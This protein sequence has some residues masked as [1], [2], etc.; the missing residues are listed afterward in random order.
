MWRKLPCYEIQCRKHILLDV[1]QG[2][3]LYENI[4]K[5]FT[6]AFLT[7]LVARLCRMEYA[8]LASGITQ[9]HELEDL[10]RAIFQS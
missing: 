3:D 8:N 10:E 6:H 4:I 9:F 5:D 2:Y 1:Q 7:F